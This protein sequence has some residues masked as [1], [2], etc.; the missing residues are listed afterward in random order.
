MG[1]NDWWTD[2]TV[3]ACVRIPDKPSPD[4]ESKGARKKTRDPKLYFRMHLLPKE[5]AKNLAGGFPG[6][7]TSAFSWFRKTVPI[8]DEPT[9]NHE[10]GK[11][12]FAGILRTE[13]KQEPAAMLGLNEMIARRSSDIG[14]A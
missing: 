4:P 8:P 11:K 2:L 1:Y 6:E 5:Q 13:K 10:W 12:V 3:V 14:G 7:N 9:S